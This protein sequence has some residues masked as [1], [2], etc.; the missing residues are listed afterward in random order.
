LKK[1]TALLSALLA[2]TCLGIAYVVIAGR[3]TNSYLLVDASTGEGFPEEFYFATVNYSPDGQFLVTSQTLVASD[4]SRTTSIWS[5]ETG[6]ELWH[7]EDVASGWI[8]G[9]SF[10]PD[11]SQ[12]VAPDDVVVLILDADTGRKLMHLD[13]HTGEVASASYSPDGQHIVTAGSDETVRVWS[14]DTGEETL[15]LRGH[16]PGDASLSALS[17]TYSADG[18]F[19]VSASADTTARVWNAQSG[20]ELLRIEGHTGPVTGASYSPNGQQIVTGSFDGTVRLWDANSGQEILRIGDEGQGWFL[21]PLF[22]PNGRYIASVRHYGE[23]FVWDATTGEIVN[24]FSPF[25]PGS[26]YHSLAYSPD[27][28]FIA[29]AGDDGLAVLPLDLD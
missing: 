29:V 9:P 19:I 25:A 18:H 28:K 11:G 6:E 1:G 26:R 8:H 14:A 16:A 7:F 20:E 24:S 13:G 2:L 15:L 27:G 4:T 3:L 10:S 5:A 12:V 23:V 22:S 21:R 17:A